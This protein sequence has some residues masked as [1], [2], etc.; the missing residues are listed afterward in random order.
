[1]TSAVPTS[2]TA[3]MATISRFLKIGKGQF[4]NQIAAVV[5]SSFLRVIATI[6][7]RLILT[8]QLQLTSGGHVISE[9]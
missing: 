7:K 3:P 6:M 8:E 9:F 2:P 4:S 1:M 5:P